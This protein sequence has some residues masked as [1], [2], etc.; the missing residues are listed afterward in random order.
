MVNFTLLCSF[1]LP[2]ESS[3]YIDF[4]MNQIGFLKEFLTS[5]LFRI[6]SACQS[7]NG[8]N[9]DDDRTYDDGDSSNMMVDTPESNSLSNPVNVQA[10]KVRPRGAAEV[11][12]GW[13]VVS[14]KRKDK[15][16]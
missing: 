13:T 11:E 6:F 1:A 12:D 14:S 3:L 7:V 2:S 16:N 9:D 5:F 15:R 4:N 8:G 10:N